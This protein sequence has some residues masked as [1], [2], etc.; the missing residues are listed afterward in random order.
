MPQS[1][2]SYTNPIENLRS[3]IM[4]KGGIQKDERMTDLEWAQDKIAAGEKLAN[5]VS[6]FIKDM[7]KPVSAQQFEAETTAIQRA[8]K[9]W[10]DL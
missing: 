9:E 7:G 10:R 3:Y 4:L 5:Q 6:D 8:L 1:R 2:R